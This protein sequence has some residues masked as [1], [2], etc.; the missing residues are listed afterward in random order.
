[1]YRAAHPP[2]F[3]SSIDQLAECLRVAKLHQCPHCKRCGTLIGHGFL[4]GYAEHSSERIIRGRRLFCSDRFLQRGCGRTVAIL[5]DTVLRTF[6]VRA[7]TLFG[8]AVSVVAGHSI[9]TAWQFACRM[10][11]LSSA[12]RLW[13]RLLDAQSKWRTQLLTVCPPPLSQASQPIA[14]LL[15]HFRVAFMPYECPFSAFQSQ[16]QSPV[17]P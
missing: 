16:L 13:Q 8:L 5:L 1:M 6:S 9:R 15:E 11:S 12:Y 3:V 4:R 2:K 10:F 17:V 7:A 14:Q